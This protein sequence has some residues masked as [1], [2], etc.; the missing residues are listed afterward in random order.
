VLAVVA[1]KLEANV[2]FRFEKCDL[3]KYNFRGNPNL[4]IYT[5]II[6]YKLL[7]SII[8]RQIT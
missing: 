8:I 3:G 6:E 7:A 4:T 2:Q 5:E 1:N